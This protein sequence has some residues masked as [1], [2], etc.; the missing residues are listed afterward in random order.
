MSDRANTKYIYILFTDTGTWFTRLIRLYTKQELN[1]VS[2]A[3]HRSLDQVY[4]FGRKRPNNPFIGGFVR[5][6]LRSPLFERAKCAIY[7]CEVS[8]EQ[9]LKAEAVLRQFERRSAIFRYNLLGLFGVMLDRPMQRK[10][11]YFCSQFVASLFERIDLPLT[12]RCAA[13]AT[14]R[15]LERSDKLV[16]V[17]RG[18]LQEAGICEGTASM[19]QVTLSAQTAP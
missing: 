9:Y 5:E 11:A 13:L 4:S 16:C 19:P 18:T 1:H 7:R 10:C 15:D 8:H 14:P 3:L 2:V 12:T 6:D 17:Y